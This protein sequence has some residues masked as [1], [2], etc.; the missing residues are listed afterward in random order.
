M[1][2]NTLV[3]L[4][5]IIAF[6]SCGF[7]W[8]RCPEIKY[9]LDSFDA[10]RYMGK[11]YE[12]MREESIIFERGTC[13]E[14]NYTLNSNGSIYVVNQEIR[15]GELNS[16]KGTAEPTSNPFQFKLSFS[17]GW[18]AKVA[19]GDYRVYFTDYENYSIVYSCTDLYL[20]SFEY[21]WVLSR[22][23]A[24]PQENLVNFGTYLKQNLGFKE[25]QILYTSQEN[26][27]RSN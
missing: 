24:L 10:P 17:K 26:C 12:I 19:K 4:L 27:G 20:F 16:V 1:K 11:W 3:I 25:S 8:G 18:I 15:N 14:A 2:G 9:Q 6:A 13:Q 7:R 5:S 23:A 21:F 22:E